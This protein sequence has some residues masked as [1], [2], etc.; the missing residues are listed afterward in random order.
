MTNDQA[1][2]GDKC[3]S[4]RH[5]N[6]QLQWWHWEKVFQQQKYEKSNDWVGFII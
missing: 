4:E 1:D 5:G 6:D 2:I 3:N